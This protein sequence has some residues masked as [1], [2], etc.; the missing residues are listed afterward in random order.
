MMHPEGRILART[1]ESEWNKLCKTNRKLS[2]P[3]KMIE[4]IVIR[5]AKTQSQKVE[6][7][8]TKA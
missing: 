3:V 2:V 1:F 7:L 4:G 5:G 6:S 8:T